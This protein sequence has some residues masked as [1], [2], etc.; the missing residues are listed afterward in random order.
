MIIA[1]PECQ[2]LNR[3]PAEKRE[4]QPSCGKCKAPL[5]PGAVLLLTA[6]NVAKHLEKS[7]WP[8]L[9]DF[10]APWCGPCQQFAPVFQQQ[11]PKWATQIRFAKLNTEQEQA[12]AARFQIRSIPTL[13]LLQRGKVIAQQ[14]GAMPGQMLD[15]WLNQNRSKLSYQD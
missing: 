6:D 7:D 13:M 4:Q 8:V 5:L 9:V 10:W 2:G 3:V 1:C 11:A 15:Q 12:L 14:A